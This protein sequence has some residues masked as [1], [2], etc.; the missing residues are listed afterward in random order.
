MWF[1]YFLAN[2]TSSQRGKTG[3]IP[4]VSPTHTHVPKKGNYCHVTCHVMVLIRAVV[5]A[6]GVYP[7]F[8]HV[9]MGWQFTKSIETTYRKIIETIY[10]KLWIFSFR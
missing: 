4:P 1:R 9:E 2:A 6:Q 10:R 8:Y 3:G 5:L 7:L